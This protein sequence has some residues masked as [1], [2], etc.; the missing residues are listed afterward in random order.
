GDSYKSTVDQI[1]AIK[2]W[3][4]ANRDWMQIAYSPRQARRII[5]AG[6][7][8]IIIGIES[9]YDFGAEDRRFDPVKRLDEYYRM[10]VR[11]FYMAHKIN[12]RLAGADIY[13]PPHT[14]PGK[15]IRNMQA[16][17]GCFFY[18]DSVAN[19]PLKN[20]LGHAFCDNKC[21][22]GFFK[23]GK[24][25]GL[26]DKCVDRPSQLSEIN[27]VDYVVGRSGLEGHFNGFA[28]Y[29]N[30]P[31]F[32][33]RGG[34]YVDKR[35][36]RDAWVE[37]NNM[38]IS[39]DGERVVRA[40]ML[41]GMIVN[42][43]HVS[44]RARIDM[45]R[46]SREFKDY[47]LNAMHNNPN[48]ML[49]GWTKSGR[50]WLHEY[51]FDDSELQ[52]VKDTGGFFGVRIGAFKARKHK[53]S[54]I[55]ISCDE[56]IVDTA[57]VLTYLM[58]DWGLPVGYSLDF[59]TTTK[60]VYS[61]RAKGNKECKDLGPDLLHTYLDKKS[62]RTFETRGVAHIGL[63]PKWHQ[64][65]KNIGLKREWRQKLENEGPERFLTMWEQSFAKRRAG[66][67]IPRRTINYNPPPDFDC[68]TDRECG[69]GQFCSQGLLPGLS[70]SKCVNERE[71]RGVCTQ[72]R[73]C[74]SGRCGAGLCARA[75]A[76]DRD[77]DCGSGKYCKTPIGV[78]EARICATKL[79]TG[80]L[81]TKSAQCASGRCGAGKCA[82][83]HACDRDS[84]CG[85]GKYC[86]TPIGVAEARI[87]Q[88]K[89][90]TG[91]L[92]TKSAQC[93]SNRCAAG[94]CA[95]AHACTTDRD[96][97]GS[98]Y[99][100]TPVGIA[101]ARVCRPKLA[102]GKLCT[103]GKQCASGCCKPHISTAGAPSCRPSN[104]C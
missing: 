9:D 3:V 54:G 68:N 66:K 90:A 82:K 2:A 19:F 60:A 10:G 20:N 74:Q 41:R 104:K 49:E 99:C 31:G 53:D 100:K 27:L 24:L 6:K 89:L 12:S 81:C 1:K 25:F 98:N 86:K 52:M 58:K 64:E 92:C 95:K 16:M 56:T 94:K 46:I 77:S 79:A 35:T 32:A 43:D 70:R 69:S 21:G 73:H 84:D 34:S 57:H 103:K 97:G 38:G 80:K 51:D 61:R 47:P 17:A 67:Q 23:G 83:A 102:Q 5:N 91:K 59:A 26:L 15:L 55:P 87:C 101:A 7:L 11:T 65:L 39:H 8:A 85:S 13:R 88:T 33:T 42:I 18:D 78:A 30:T 36:Y 29:P 4:A 75:H 63:M 14:T 22:K 71:Y 28:I 76:C 37:R 50:R 48:A 62:G 40:A 96:C 44:S 72:G 93:A 45:R